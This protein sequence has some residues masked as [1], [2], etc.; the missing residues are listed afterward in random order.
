M[1]SRLRLDIVGCSSRLNLDDHPICEDNSDYLIVFINS[2]MYCF[3]LTNLR[4]NTKAMKINKLKFTIVMISNEKLVFKIGEKLLIN[5]AKIK[6][7][8][9][10]GG[11]LDCSLSFTVYSKLFFCFQL[12]CP[13]KHHNKGSY[14]VTTFLTFTTVLTII[15]RHDQRVDGASNNRVILHSSSRR[16][17]KE[18]ALRYG[19]VR[20]HCFDVSFVL[21]RR[22][23]IG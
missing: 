21:S 12:K 4:I 6:E 23:L 8:F 13:P 3:S 7:F 2:R 17:L 15:Y 1:E 9:W 11:F 16:L 14:V 19:V 10:G 18:F 20:S 22:K 5:W